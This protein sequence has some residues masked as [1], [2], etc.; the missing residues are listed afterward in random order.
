MEIVRA[1]ADE[2]DAIVDLFR[3]YDFALKERA[4]FD[5]KH[6]QNPFGAPHLFKLVQDGELAGTVGLLAQPFRHD[7]RELTAVQAVDGLMGRA[8]RGKGLFND[9]MFFVM[10]TVPDGVAGPRFGTGFASLPGSMKALENAGW[11]RLA[12][13]RVRK[14]LLSAR[15]LRRLPGGA[16]L[17]RLLVPVWGLMRAR[18]FAGAASD[19]AVVEVSRFDEDLDRF[20]PAGRVAGG[21]SAAFLN[22]RVLDNPRDQMRAFTFRLDGRLVGYAICK[23]RPATWEVV[24]FRTELP[25]RGAAAA[26]LKHLHARRL[27]DSVDFWLLDGFLQEDHLPRGLLER[28]TAGAMFVHG[29]EWA[30]L[31]A[32]PRAWAAS[33][34]DSDW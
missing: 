21:R 27:V 6:L 4:W 22:W 32:D 20:Q 13:F 14:A 3:A 28:G 19:L 31:P 10:G 18:L 29:I 23:V 12:N 17:W 7:G 33:Y 24:E 2:F 34:L 11:R 15:A 9:V 1:H 26:F 5:W 30:G 8:I 25:G 16:L